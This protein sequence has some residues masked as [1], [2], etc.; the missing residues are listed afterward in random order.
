[1][2][3]NRNEG[4]RPGATSDDLLR[5]AEAGARLETRW[6]LR[7][8]E[9]RGTIRREVLARFRAELRAEGFG[10]YADESLMAAVQRGVEAVLA[11]APRRD[12]AGSPGSVAR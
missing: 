6:R 9:E 3:A 2:L 4:V 7:Q 1:M 10:P 12:P 5:V 11:E 8:G